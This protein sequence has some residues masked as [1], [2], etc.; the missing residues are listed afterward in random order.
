MVK[1]TEYLG[2]II[3][4]SEL[5]LQ[6]IRGKIFK[7][8][9]ILKRSSINLCDAQTK[10]AIWEAYSKIYSL[11]IIQFKC[12]KKL[13]GAYRYFAYQI[14]SKEL[15]D[16]KRDHAL[17]VIRNRNIFKLMPYKLGHKHMYSL[18]DQ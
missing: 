3:G 2:V 15:N 1:S 10:R 18:V 5:A 12:L 6:D 8:A 7:R 14:F 11:N 13:S 16:I 17:D 9:N 4:V